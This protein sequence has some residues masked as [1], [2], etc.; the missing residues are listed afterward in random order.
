MSLP[1]GAVC[2]S[3]VRDSGVM[4]SNS[5][6]CCC[7]CFFLLPVSKK[8]MMKWTWLIMAGTRYFDSHRICVD[9][10]NKLPC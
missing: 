3:S 2:W 5:L 10:S 4:G 6:V 7:C 9:A 1:H 8:N